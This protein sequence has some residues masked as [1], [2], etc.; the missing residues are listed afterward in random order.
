MKEQDT[1]IRRNKER[2]ESTSTYPS[3]PVGPE[4]QLS[5]RA[6]IFVLCVWRIEPPGEDISVLVSTFLGMQYE[7]DLE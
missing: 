3:N 1:I 7:A 5:W 6:L 4:D 2:G